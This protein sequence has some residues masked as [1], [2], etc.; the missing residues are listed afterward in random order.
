[1]GLTTKIQEFQAVNLQ[2]K[3]AKKPLATISQQAAGFGSIML[4]MD[5]LRSLFQHDQ[6]LLKEYG[7]A[8]QR[9]LLHVEC[10]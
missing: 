5:L 4:Q 1:M 3:S 7:L 10:S 2:L 8:H 6:G 9:S